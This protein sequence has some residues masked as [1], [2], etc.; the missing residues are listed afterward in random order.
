MA[1]KSP[2][3]S[4]ANVD[5]ASTY[6]APM[7]SVGFHLISALG[8]STCA[9]FL[10]FLPLLLLLL[11]SLLLLL[12]LLLWVFWVFYPSFEFE[13]EAQVEKKE[14]AELV[15]EKIMALR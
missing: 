1:Q 14:T 6:L 2:F 15:G 9:M 7:Y 12:L 13:S 3:A 11:L 5:L 8:V 10:C 4:A